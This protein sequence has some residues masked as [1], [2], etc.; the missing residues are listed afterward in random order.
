MERLSSFADLL[1]LQKVDAGV[2]KLLND[3]RNLPEL[4]EHAEAGRG[5]R[6]GRSGFRRSDQ[7]DEESGP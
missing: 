7:P 4:A 1:E 3:R 6:G 2:D 5:C